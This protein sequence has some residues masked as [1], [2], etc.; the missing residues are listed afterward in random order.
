LVSG[1]SIGTSLSAINANTPSG[2]FFRTLMD[3][4]LIDLVPIRDIVGQGT[5]DQHAG[6]NSPID[7]DAVQIRYKGPAQLDDTTPGVSMLPPAVAPSVPRDPAYAPPTAPP[8]PG[9]GID[10]SLRATY[11]NM[12][13]T[14]HLD[15]GTRA[16]IERE[17]GR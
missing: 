17:L 12:L 13:N 15:P 9:A 11:E 14:S 7:P 8:A 5:L 6:M 10:D 1:G 2:H 16:A 3:Q 4:G